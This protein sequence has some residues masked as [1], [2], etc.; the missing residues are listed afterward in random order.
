MTAIG[1]LN[2]CKNTAMASGCY[3]RRLSELLQEQQEP[4]LV[5]RNV[6]RR[7][8]G[9]VTAVLRVRKALLLWDLCFSCGARDRF[10]RLPVHPGD[11]DRDGAR[12]LSPVSV[13]ELRCS[14]DDEL[15][16]TRTHCKKQLV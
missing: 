15:T 3:G 9:N 5:H 12:Q 1:L 10:R 6:G 11:D 16:T 13:L 7:G 14:D 2:D 4:F 8:A